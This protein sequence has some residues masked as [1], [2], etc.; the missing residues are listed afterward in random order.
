MNLPKDQILKGCKNPEGIAILLK[1]AEQV[2]NT[3]QP[4]WSL[5]VSAPLR[6]EALRILKPLNE[7]RFLT[8][9]GHPQAERHRILCERSCEEKNFLFQDP[10]L[11]GIVI[12]GNFLFDKPSTIELRESINSRGIKLDS[13]GDI[14]IN[15][16]RFA[17]AI[18]TPEAAKEINGKRTKLRDIV[19]HFESLTLDQIKFPFERSP[20]VFSTIEAS[21]RIDAIASAGFGISRAK[22]SRHI[23]E[24]HLR[25]NWEPIKTC[26]KVVKIGDSINHKEKGTI[27]IQQL[28]L[29]KRQRW[30]VELLRT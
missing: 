3:Y 27:K 7:L 18:C 4:S 10:P 2:L 29:T 30:R 21:L 16:D 22:I 13:I 25:L 6:E 26:S 11:L 12:E 23:K 9:G 5:F 28:Y 24:G 20:K 1:Q 19:I 8:A 17:Y 15:N 14:W